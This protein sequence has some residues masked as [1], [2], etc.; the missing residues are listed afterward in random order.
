AVIF[1][2]GRWSVTDHYGVGLPIFDSA[3]NCFRW[4]CTLGGCG[5]VYGG[6]NLSVVLAW[7]RVYG[8][9][10]ITAVGTSAHD[11]ARGVV[12]PADDLS[13]VCFMCYVRALSSWH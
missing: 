9:P 10:P 11:Y 12:R 3:T 6:V 1:G 8:L 13:S 4:F 2:R 7:W 5:N